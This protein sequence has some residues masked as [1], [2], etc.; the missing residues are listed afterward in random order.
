MASQIFWNICS[1]RA[2]GEKAD[3]RRLISI[4]SASWSRR[5]SGTCE[6]AYGALVER[7]LPIDM[8]FD[9]KVDQCLHHPWIKFC[10]DAYNAAEDIA[11]STWFF[12]A[13]VVLG[14]QERE[15]DAASLLQ[16]ASLWE[17]ADRKIGNL[18]CSNLGTLS[19]SRWRKMICCLV[20]FGTKAKSNSR[21][22]TTFC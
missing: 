5:G 9:T 20:S 18:Q 13:P 21:D 6:H 11:L 12:G 1:N 8:K 16:A 4:T 17:T 10:A 22:T 3:S 14:R 2:K 19:T 15:Y 7:A